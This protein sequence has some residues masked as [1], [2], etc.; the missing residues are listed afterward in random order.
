MKRFQSEFH[1]WVLA[2]N[3]AKNNDHDPDKLLEALC[4]RI[5]E[6]RQ[7][8]I[9]AALLNGWLETEKEPGRGYF[10]RETDRPGK[11][12]GQPTIT[13]YGGG[14]VAPWWELFVQLADYGWLRSIAERHRQEVRLEDRLMDLTVSSSDR[15][16]LYVE[17]KEKAALAKKLLEG[18]KYYGK[19]GFDLNDPDKGNDP[20]KKAKYLVKD[21]THPMFFGL[22][23]VGYRKLFRIEYS[24]DNRFNLIEDDR[25]F[26]APLADY[27]GSSEI[28][29]RPW[30][31]V[32]PLA[33][34]IE[35]FCP[36]VWISVG[37][38]KTAYNFY[39][40]GNNGDAII[41][42][43][44]EEG[45]VWTDIAGLGM[46][47]AEGFAF[48]LSESGI[49]LDTSKQ[50]CF[51]KHGGSNLNLENV[52]PVDIACTVRSVLNNNR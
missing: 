40:P 35:R 30:S 46:E 19:T 8:H 11:H 49:D 23:A 38:G 6:D 2:Y 4:K 22:S 51:W 37:A 16:I 26:S 20:L 25:G 15:L 32:D 34:E 43:V 13:H 5:P 14:N 47:L 10:V 45:K 41:I 39:I 28:P 17:H 50:W 7:R 27:P 24:N 1:R 12:G 3:A 36:E 9:G 42:G 52:D 31:P 33:S 44:Y 29:K 21:G 18:V 48:E